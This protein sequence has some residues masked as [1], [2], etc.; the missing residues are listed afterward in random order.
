MLASGPPVDTCFY[1]YTHSRTE[2]VTAF[3]EIPADPLSLF[4]GNGHAC[5]GSR[6]VKEKKSGPAAFDEMAAPDGRMDL[7]VRD[8]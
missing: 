7:R 8:A 6:E 3:G 1:L 2:R 5:G 4:A